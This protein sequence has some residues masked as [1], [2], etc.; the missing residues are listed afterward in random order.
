MYMFVYEGG[1]GVKILEKMATWFVH[2]PLYRNLII[3]FPIGIFR[4]TIPDLFTQILV[5]RMRCEWFGPVIKK[6]IQN[7]DFPITLG[8]RVVFAHIYE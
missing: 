5:K 2:D 7:I 8:F 1:G 4:E 3:N 6:S